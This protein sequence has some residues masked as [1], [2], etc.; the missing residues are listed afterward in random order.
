MPDPGESKKLSPA[1]NPTP[2]ITVLAPESFI[3][4]GAQSFDARGRGGEGGP[5]KDGSFRVWGL[6]CLGFLGFVVFRGF[7]VFVIVFRVSRVY[8]V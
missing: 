5:T 3:E 1:L 8:R 6:W 2:R 4:A 7:E